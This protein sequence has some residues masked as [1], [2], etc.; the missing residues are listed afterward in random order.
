MIGARRITQGDGVRGEPLFREHGRQVAAL[1]WR[2]ARQAAQ[3]LL[4]TSLSTRRWILPKGWQE[5][6]MT[7]S[8]AAA[9]EA[10]EEAGVTGKIAGK[11]L[12]SYHYLKDRK[13]GGAVPCRV[14]VFLLEVTRQHDDWPEKGEREVAWLT[15]AQAAAR[16]SEPGLRLILRDFAKQHRSAP[17]AKRA[18]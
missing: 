12:A 1:C 9:R 10:F 16:V 15:P 2:P 18:G 7:P 8:A 14:D 17:P 6:G 13:D 11:A 5:E 4:I 3:I